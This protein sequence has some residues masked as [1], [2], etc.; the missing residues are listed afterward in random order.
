MM[1]SVW[2]DCR[3]AARMLIKNPGFT[4]IAVL[5]LAVGIGANTAT[6]TLM[7]ALLLKPIVAEAPH[8]LVALYSKNLKLPDSFR[9]ISYPNFEDIR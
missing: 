4:S 2:Q 3:Y 9:P 7:N 5:V 8:E 1:D 6:F